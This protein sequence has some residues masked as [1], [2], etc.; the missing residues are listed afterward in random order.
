MHNEGRMDRIKNLTPILVFIAVMTLLSVGFA[1]YKAVTAFS[2]TVES[3]RYDSQ[4]PIEDIGAVP[5]KLSKLEG[6][7]QEPR[8]NDEQ[9]FSIYSG[10][11][12]IAAL[13]S[14]GKP[15]ASALEN[16]FLR[17]GMPANEANKQAR[18]IEWPS[19]IEISGKIEISNPD[20]E[21]ASDYAIIND[22]FDYGQSGSLNTAN[23]SISWTKKDGGSP[24]LDGVELLW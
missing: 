17:L 19:G 4:S 8:W 16:V 12:E 9:M 3:P 7:E 2:G 1:V 5:F 23:L 24:T 22:Y 21:I 6:Q 14:K 18:E 20:L 10:S 11:Q 15:S 13:L